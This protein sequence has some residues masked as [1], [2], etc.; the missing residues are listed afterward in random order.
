MPTITSAGSWLAAVPAWGERCVRVCGEQVLPALSAA[1]EQLGRPMRIMLYTDSPEL[2]ALAGTLFANRATLEPKAVP[3][4]DG[5]FMSMSA[6]HQNAMEYAGHGERVLL[7]TADMVVSRELLATCEALAA[8]GVLAVGCVGMRALEGGAGLPETSAGASDGGTGGGTAPIG[9]TGREL[10][11]WAWENRHPMTREC[12]W[13]EGR[14]YDVW[15][16]YFEKGGEVAA[17]VFLPH[18]IMVVPAGIPINF[19]PTI[20]VNLLA[21]F[22]QAQT[23]MITSPEEGAVIELSPFDKQFNMTTTMRERAESVELHPSCP[24]FVQVTHQRHRMFFG[25]RVVIM[26]AGGDCGDSEVVERVLG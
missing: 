7:L 18:P 12:T 22:T 3:V 4:V 17:R 9:A 16:M 1:L 24:A 19:S 26:G 13:P 14:S 5:A 11:A 15:R 2:V 8:R 21:C 6:C 10:L 23:Y 20:D 25:K